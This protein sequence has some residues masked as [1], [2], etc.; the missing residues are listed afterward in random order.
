MAHGGTS[1]SR[2]TRPRSR[3][4]PRRRTSASKPEA[5]AV[6][7]RCAR[8]RARPPCLG[9]RPHEA[10]SSA[11]RMLGSNCPAALDRFRQPHSGKPC[12]EGIE[13][14]ASR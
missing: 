5:P 2:L 11:G 14:E 9:Y 8:R 7:N 1:G 12:H 10:I 6:A 13:M 4:W 3:P